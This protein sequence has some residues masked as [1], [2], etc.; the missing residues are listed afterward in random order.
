MLRESVKL[1]GGS[2][3]FD[4]LTDPSCTE[5]RG[6][7]NS[8]ELLQFTNACLGDDAAALAAT[9][10]AL[11][12]NM[13]SGALVDTVGV[14]SNFQRMVRIADA[15]GIP[16]DDAMLVMSADLREQLGINRYVSAA[17]SEQPPFFQRLLLKFVAVR[18]FRKM[19]REASKAA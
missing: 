19:I 18:Q 12:D 17:N 5:I 15:T 11:V 8:H 4:G 16:S 1:S 10:Q 14:I 7:P 6:V 9:R 13:G 3:D 2:I